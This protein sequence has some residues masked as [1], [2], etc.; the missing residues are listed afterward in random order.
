MQ[1]EIGGQQA[2]SWAD[3]VSQIDREQDRDSEREGGG[4][5]GI[6]QTQRVAV[7]AV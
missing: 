4:D 7:I 6:S 2:E 1:L 5:W 3:C